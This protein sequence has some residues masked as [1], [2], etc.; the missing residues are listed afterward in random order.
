MNFAFTPEQLMIGE[1]ARAFFT[2]NAISERTRKAMADDGIDRALWQA[3]CTELGLGGISLPEA[4]GGA[5]L[6]MVEFAL[7]AEAAG[8]QVAAIPLLGLATAAR[9]IAAGWV[10]LAEGRVASQ[11]NLRR[12]DCRLRGRARIHHRGWPAHRRH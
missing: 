5:G 4:H 2:E 6:G 7:I 11:A 9:A 1:T 10:G 3:F 8:A 12:G